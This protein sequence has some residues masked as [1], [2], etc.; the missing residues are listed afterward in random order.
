MHKMPRLPAS[1]VASAALAFWTPV[2][3]QAAEVQIS[4]Q[5]PVVDL[6]VTETV[7]S[8]PDTA[9]FSTGVETTAATAT[10][11]LRQNSRQVRVLIDKLKSLGIAQKDIQTTGISLN[12]NYDYDRSTREN[13][14]T[15]YRVSNQVSAKV[16]NLDDLGRILDALVSEGGATS[17]N[18]PYFSVRDDSELKEQ[19]RNRALQSAREQAESYAAISGFS[20]V[21]LL[22]ISETLRNSSPAGPV[23]MRAMVAEADASVPISAGQVGTSVT[24]QISFEMIP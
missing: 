24:L 15:G 20:G 12:A 21:K 8:V 2:T 3:L 16:R 14:F 11:A 18:G 7:E 10:Q 22:S 13:R 23:P 1:L 9:S 6:R 4:A 19:A 17:L 5:H